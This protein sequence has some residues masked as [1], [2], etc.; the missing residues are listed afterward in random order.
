MNFQSISVPFSLLNA[1]HLAGIV[2]EFHL[3]FAMQ[4]IASLSQWDCKRTKE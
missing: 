2:A 3:P 4:H 1:V